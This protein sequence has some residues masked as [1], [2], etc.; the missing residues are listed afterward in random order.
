MYGCS[1]PV[2]PLL[3]GYHWLNYLLGKLIKCIVW[4]WLA[5]TKECI[6]CRLTILPVDL[7]EIWKTG[8]TLRSD[9]RSEAEAW[10]KTTSKAW[11][12]D[13][14]NILSASLCNPHVFWL[15]AHMMMEFGKYKIYFLL[16][17]LAFWTC[18]INLVEMCYLVYLKSMFTFFYSGKCKWAV[19]FRNSHTLPWI[20]KQSCSSEM[21]VARMLFWEKHHSW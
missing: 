6:D 21:N 10:V 9:S 5:E 3:T 14:Q 13:I 1:W 15:F 8:H 16:V 19:A 12:L 4:C 7:E 17:L 2:L 20:K 18:L 11:Y